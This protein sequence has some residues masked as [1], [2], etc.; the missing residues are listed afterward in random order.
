MLG[1]LFFLFL[2]LF[3]YFFFPSLFQSAEFTLEAGFK[4][5]DNPHGYRFSA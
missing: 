3:H 5:L 1:T 4:V 2:F